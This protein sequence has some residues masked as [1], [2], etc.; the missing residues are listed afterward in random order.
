MRKKFLSFWLTW[1]LLPLTDLLVDIDTPLKVRLSLF[2]MAMA[3]AVA[4][5]VTTEDGERKT[6]VVVSG[7]LAWWPRGGCEGWAPVGN[8]MDVMLSIAAGQ[9]EGITGCFGSAQA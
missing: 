1:L 4:G 9:N 5:V 2:G 6:A 8:C 3:V 7:R